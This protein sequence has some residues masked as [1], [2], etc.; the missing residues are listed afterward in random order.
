[1]YTRERVSEEG[2]SDAYIATDTRDRINWDG[3]MGYDAWSSGCHLPMAGGMSI[4]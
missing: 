4:L 2:V 3:Y 1:V